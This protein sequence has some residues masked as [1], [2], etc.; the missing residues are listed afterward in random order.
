MGHPDL[1]VGPNLVPTDP[2]VD[3]RRRAVLDTLLV[4]QV[5]KVLV[6]LPRPATASQ[7][8][9]LIQI[10]MREENSCGRSQCA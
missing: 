1:E 6:D 7:R 2:V 3:V 10:S 5:V 8:G 9:S 4:V